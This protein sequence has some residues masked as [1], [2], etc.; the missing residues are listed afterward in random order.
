MVWRGEIFNVTARSA[1]LS[2]VASKS[3][4]GYSGQRIGLVEVQI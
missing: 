2:S 3:E 1:A 4:Q